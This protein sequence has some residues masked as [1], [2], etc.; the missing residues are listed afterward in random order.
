MNNGRRRSHRKDNLMGKH[1]KRIIGIVFLSLLFILGF[2]NQ[3]NYNLAPFLKSREDIFYMLSLPE[4]QRYCLL[5]GNVCSVVKIIEELPVDT[6]LY[7]VPV[8]PDTPG[9]DQNIFWWWHLNH[10]LRYFCY[11]R[12]IV[13]LHFILYDDNKAEYMQKFMEGKR[14]FSELGWIKSRGITRLL[15]YRNNRV[16]IAPVTMSIDDFNF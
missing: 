16:A 8:F 10:I 2:M 5:L 12:K 11:P 15:I 4:P 6:I 9:A 14:R 1:T 13:V 3:W 7:F